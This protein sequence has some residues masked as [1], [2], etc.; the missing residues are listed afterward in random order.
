MKLLSSDEMRR[1]DQ[2]TI[3]E[4]GLPGLVLMENAG[5]A[6]TRL[7]KNR[8]LSWAEKRILILAGTGNNGGDGFVIARR[9]L[10]SGARVNLLLFG[11]RSRLTPDARQ[12]A[13]I[14]ANLGGHIKE[15]TEAELLS[16]FPAQLAHAGLVVDA[17]FGTGLHRPIEG[18]IATTIQQV[19][20]QNI[21]VLAVDLPSGVCADS[22]KILGCALKADWTVTFAAEKRGHRL[23]P[24]AA[25]CGEIITVPIGIPDSF[26]TIESHEV[27]RNLADNFFIPPRHSTG[28]KGHF[29]HLLIVGGSLG[30]EG[31]ATLTGLGALRTGPGL[32]TIA[33][34]LEAHPAIATQLLEAMTLPLPP[35]REGEDLGQLWSNTLINSDIRPS[36]LAIGPG[37]GTNAGLFGLIRTL[38]HH[39]PDCPLILDADGLNLLAQNG[40]DWPNLA[41]DRSGPVI[42]TPHPGE[43]ARLLKISISK[44][45]DNRLDIAREHA[46][47]WQVWLVLKGA[48][49]IIAAPDG[50]AW[51]NDTGNSGLAS[52][53]SGD[54]LTGIIAGLLTQGWPVESSVRA[55]VWLHGKAADETVQAQGGEAGL[56]AHDLLPA[57]I[58]LRNQLNRKTD[59][60]SK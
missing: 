51:I 16:N 30:K 23:Y 58:R 15:I 38:G 9:L 27:A 50:R 45:Q 14:F 48:D 7:L 40:S 19:N 57:L 4:I 49:T 37:L 25:C 22:G 39:W 41:F 1:A 46:K 21:P 55:G 3:E 8:F 44:I 10:Q 47:Q 26:I 35:E 24:G 6:T 33:T 32:V 43:M 53:G 18:H 54:L 29:G 11:Q 28:H 36:A 52:G 17:L 56:L 5:A 42:L 31:A 13:D 20:R 2:R 12:N 59:R 34:P 60:T